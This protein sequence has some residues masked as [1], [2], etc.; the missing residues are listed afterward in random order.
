MRFFE[1]Q[2]AES[3][4]PTA[5]TYLHGHDY[6]ELYFLF[7]GQKKYISQTS[8]YNLPINSVTITKPYSLH[9]FEGGPFKRVLLTVTPDCLSPFQAEFLDK[10]SEQ[11][12]YTFDE[13]VMV[14]I[15]KLLNNM[16]DM[17]S[18]ISPDK[19]V[20]VQLNFGYLLYLLNK[21]MRPLKSTNES[22]IKTQTIMH[23]IVLKAVEYINKHYTENIS[24]KFLCDMF[25]IS[26]TWLCKNFVES[27]HCT[28]TN[29]QII[30]RISRAKQLLT[31]YRDK[32]I[33]EISKSLG[34]SSPKYF[35]LAF[36]R[37]MHVS[38]LQ[39]RKLI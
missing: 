18:K 3:S 27:M 2:S 15:G 39:Y 11:T 26:K 13:R 29:Y 34:F 21:Y 22:T 37:V 9:M 31:N 4:V 36:K 38:P 33:E 14:K 25:H 35:G 5:M 17:Q 28:I 20:K 30:L 16:M 10:A 19:D 12:V 1:I 32:P 7:E 6:Y 24:I 8:L 23:P